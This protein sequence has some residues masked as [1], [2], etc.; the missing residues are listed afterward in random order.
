MKVGVV[1]TS[2]PRFSGDSAGNFVAGFTRWL[3]S[4]GHDVEVV[5]AGPGSAN[6]G[7]I[8]V[9]RIDSGLFYAGGA[10]DALERSV[11]PSL[12]V[13]SFCASHAATVK[14]LGASWDAVVSHWILPSGIAVKLAVH[15]RPHLA[16]SHGADANWV[17]CPGIADG[18]GAALR[19][20]RISFAGEH[21]RQRFLGALRF[22]RAA[23]ERASFSCPMGIDA[24]VRGDLALA[25]RQL[26]L[27]PSDKVVGFLGR[28]VPIKGVEVLLRAARRDW[29][30]LV[31]GDGPERFRLQALAVAY[32]ARVRF[33]G[34]VHGETAGSFW[35]AIDVLALPSVSLPNGRIEGTPTVALEALAAGVPLVASD[36]G[37]IRNATDGAA[38]LVPPGDVEKLDGAI[39]RIFEDSG[40]RTRRVNLGRLVGARF[41]WSNV[42]PTL[43]NA[44]DYSRL[45]VPVVGSQE[46]PAW[47]QPLQAHSVVPGEHKGAQWPDRQTSPQPQGGSQTRGTHTPF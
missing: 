17:S 40:E 30:V 35:S 8:P 12:R 2:Y 19:G 38:W 26:G 23:M 41:G 10:P 1:T 37:G 13:P 28:L 14:R 4:Q 44:L 27:A 25:R 20:A 3:H 31:A 15:G 16:I 24:P 45:Q 34:Q 43:W 39:D 7:A 18:V 33:L 5:A 32:G 9:E 47:Q 46:S 36:A 22:G 21:L 42:G 11:G 29:T 6:D